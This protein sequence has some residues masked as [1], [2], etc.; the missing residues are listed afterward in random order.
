MVK[1]A[2]TIPI[3]TPFIMMF[4]FVF[5]SVSKTSFSHYES[6][7]YKIGPRLQADELEKT[8]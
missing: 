5:D 6:L 4:L 2:I 8:H 3:K 7:I 1:R